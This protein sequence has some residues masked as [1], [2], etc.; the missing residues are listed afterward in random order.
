MQTSA[1]EFTGRPRTAVGQDHGCCGCRSSQEC[2]EEVVARCTTSVVFRRYRTKCPR[3]FGGDELRFA[4]RFEVAGDEGL[5]QTPAVGQLKRR[6]RLPAMRGTAAAGCGLAGASGEASTLQKDAEER[7]T[8]AAIEHAGRCLEDQIDHAPVKT[9][10]VNPKPD[11]GHEVIETITQQAT[12]YFTRAQSA[13]IAPVIEAERRQ[14]RESLQQR[15]EA[16]EESA[17][18]RRKVQE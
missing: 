4:Q 12:L 13:R 7:Q 9:T 11:G 18:A 15:R 8:I 3:V 1:D 2:P 14:Q 6:P 16:A 10:T 17:V 5:V